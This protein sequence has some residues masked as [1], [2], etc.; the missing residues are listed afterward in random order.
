MKSNFFKILTIFFAAGLLILSGCKK[1]DPDAQ[2]AEDDARGGYI[3]SDAFAV[4][5]NQAGGGGGKADLPGCVEVYKNDVDTIILTFNDNCEYR[6]A[7]RNGSIII[8]YTLLAD[9]G[10]RAVE[11]VITFDNYS[12]NDIGVEGTIT[13]TF[14]GTYIKPA[15][16]VVATDMVATFSDSRTISWSSNK[17]FTILNGFGDGDISTNVIE[18]SGTATGVNRNGVSYTARYDAVTVDRSCEYGYPVSGTVT[19]VSENGTSVID[20]GDGACDN[21]ITVTNGKIS[22]EVKL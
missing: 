22:V 7:V 5:N 3:M 19:I 11:F 6:G 18:M 9:I 21:I 14:G 1:P 13:T 12:I 16:N 8:K 17:T 15:I 10:L 20:Y 2:S 4:G